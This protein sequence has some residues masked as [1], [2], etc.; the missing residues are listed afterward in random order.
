MPRFGPNEVGFAVCRAS[1]GRLVAGPVSH[2]TPTSV[3][4][5]VKCPA[6]SKF[7]YLF[8]THPGGVPVPSPTDV[9]SAQLSGAKGLC[10]DADGA[11][12]CYQMRR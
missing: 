6:N 10:I 12:R 8:H 3:S 9:R 7:E 11:M 4:I 2:G 5:D 1:S